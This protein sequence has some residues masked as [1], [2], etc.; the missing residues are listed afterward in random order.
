MGRNQ[1]FKQ[2]VAIV[3]GASSGIGR[4]IALA[5]AKAGA[6]VVLAARNEEKL[7]NAAFDCQQHSKD[8]LPVV[9]DVSDPDQCQNLIDQTIQHFQRLDIL[10]NNAGISMRA[11]FEEMDL[12]VMEKTMAIN[13]WGTIYCTHAAMPY[14]LD[15][16][17]W[18][19]GISSI[20]GYRGLP[21]R[22]AYSASKFAMNGFLEA[23][24][25]ENR[26]TGLKVLTVCPGFTE[27][28]IRES[29]L[30]A[31]GQAQGSSPRAESNM[32]QPEDVAQAMLKAMRKKQKTLILTRQGRLTVWL[33]KW[34]NGFMDRLVFNHM[35]QEPDSP[36][37]E[38]PKD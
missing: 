12:S 24:R 34:A 17:G 10:V 33:N 21:A 20:A 26:K 1:T 13:F 19:I 27:S 22:T 9:T 32:M 15:S 6:C 37:R 4:G 35:N 23:L 30:D 28:N 8:V 29:A 31:Q 18:V 14:L 38:K 25:T 5:L 2:K 3:T 11:L 36:L 7:Q 16:Q